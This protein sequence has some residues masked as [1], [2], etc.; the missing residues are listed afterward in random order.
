MP[1]PPWAGGNERDRAILWPREGRLCTWEFTPWK[2]L[3]YFQTV[4]PKLKLVESAGTI[5]E[6]FTVFLG[7][8]PSVVLLTEAGETFIRERQGFR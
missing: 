6:E 1:S 5:K 4:F 2:P 7:V 3:R 8:Q